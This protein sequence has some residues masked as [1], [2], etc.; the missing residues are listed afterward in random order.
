MANAMIE[1]SARKAIN[2]VEVAQ[3]DQTAQITTL[4]LAI[5]LFARSDS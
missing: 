2:Q 1:E 5:T 4:F 3:D